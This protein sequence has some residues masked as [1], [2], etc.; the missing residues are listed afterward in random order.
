M[1]DSW[2]L[3]LFSL[4]SNFYE[5]KLT[6]FSYSD[7]NDDI[8]VSVSWKVGNWQNKMRQLKCK[9]LGHHQFKKKEVCFCWRT[10]SFSVRIYMCLFQQRSFEIAWD[11]SYRSTRCDRVGV[12]TIGILQFILTLYDCTC[13]QNIVCTTL[14]LFCRIVD[15]KCL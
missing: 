5:Q 14:K 13:Y 2:F 3:L 4:I 8:F 7:Q 9:T 10:W 11:T 12:I 6:I 15:Q 1:C